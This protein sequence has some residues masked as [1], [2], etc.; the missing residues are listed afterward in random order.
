MVPIL[1]PI[2]I[3]NI[4]T[5]VVFNII[6]LPTLKCAYHVVYSFRFSDQNVLRN[7]LVYPMRATCLGYLI[8]LDLVPPITYGNKNEL[9]S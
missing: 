8:I 3:P 2:N 5:V 4:H 9:Q 1:N 7:S 6:P